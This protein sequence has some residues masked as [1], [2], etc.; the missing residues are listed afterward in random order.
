MP[1]AVEKYRREDEMIQPSYSMKRYQ[2][3]KNRFLFSLVKEFF[4]R[5]FPK[6]FSRRDGFPGPSMR[7]KIANELIC[8]FETHNPP[9]SRFQCG[10]VFWNALD[11]KTRADSPNRRFVPVVL[12]LVTE[13]DIDQLSKGVRPSVITRNTIARIMKEAY[14]Q[15]GI[16][17][18]RDVALLMLRG[19]ANISQL[20]KQY[21]KEHN[22]ILPHTGALHDMGSCVSHKTMII[23]K[24]ILQKKDPALVARECNHSQ[25]AVDHY[26]KDY[27]RVKTVY[28]HNT[29]PNYIHHVT[30]I[31]QH[32]VKEYI[33]IISHESEVQ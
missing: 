10:Q 18:T 4:T 27:H 19:V 29:D 13:N 25:L 32:V 5:E 17:S 9:S 12:S 31:A 21:E 22:C 33:N 28:E 23:N 8:I 24:V 15:G 14:E 6:F 1:L 11:Q 3:A 2:S 26:L 7:D 30:G 20:R 16:L